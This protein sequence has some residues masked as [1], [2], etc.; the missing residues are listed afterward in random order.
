MSSDSI[1][2]IQ[3][4]QSNDREGIKAIYTAFLPRIRTFILRNGGKEEDAQDVF[5][6]AL[7][8]LFDKSRAKGFVLSSGFYTLLYGICRNL[9]GNQLQKKSRTE[10][11]LNDDIK[12][13]EQATQL[14]ELLQVEKQQLFWDSFQKLGTEC[15]E[16][17]ELFFTKKSMEE[18]AEI[19]SLSSSGYAKKRKFLCKEQLIQLVRSDPRFTSYHK[20][21]KL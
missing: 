11:T 15:Q 1:N 20:T 8:I 19:L 6:D 21:T 4:I 9:W 13:I 18:I 2:Y 12:Y 16:L 5:Q 17:L 3:A 10:V 7:L 14:D